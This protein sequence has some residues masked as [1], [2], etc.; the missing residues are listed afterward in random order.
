MQ[1]YYR[2]EQELAKQ[3]SYFQQS[4]F[5]RF[6]SMISQTGQTAYSQPFNP[7]SSPFPPPQNPPPPQPQDLPTQPQDPPT[8]SQ[9]P[10]TQFRYPPTQFQ[11]PPTQF[12]YPSTQ[13]QHPAHATQ[14]QFPPGIYVP[15]HP[16]WSGPNNQVDRFIH[17]QEYTVL[18]GRKAVSPDTVINPDEIR[19]HEIED[20]EECDN[21][22]PK[23]KRKASAGEIDKL[24]KAKLDQVGPMNV[25]TK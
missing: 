14:Y 16:P 18:P 25:K 1:E 2:F 3:N 20:E 9:H 8:Q 5:Q 12:Q 4:S 24:K 13:S 7:M 10:Y 23:L 21:E 11:Y 6:Q 17:Q 15:L 22:E 19:C